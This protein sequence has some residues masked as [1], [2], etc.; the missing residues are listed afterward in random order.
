M[1]IIFV[2]H[3]E[4]DYARD[5]LT[6]EGLRQAEAAA[7][8]LSGEGITRIFSS[9]NGRAKQT[10]AATAKRLGLPMTVLDYMHEITWGGPGIPVD[11]HPWTLGDWLLEKD[12]FDFY[13]RDWQQHPWFKGNAATEDYRRVTARFDALLQSFGYI[14]DG[15][16]FLCRNASAET[17]ALFSHGG[18]GACALSGLLSLPF[19]YVACV[20]PYDFTSVIIVELPVREGEY[21]HPRLELFNDV[22]HIRRSGGR[23]RLQERPDGD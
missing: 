15:R 5:C 19:P 9:P 21:V 23:P 10:A 6:D 16:R 18:S 11:G 1:R 4:P 14:H 22:A 20:L 12:N 3:G 17:I 2:R 7:E 13:A 8:R